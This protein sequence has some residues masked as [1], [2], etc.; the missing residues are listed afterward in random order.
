VLP[1]RTQATKA[2][3]PTSRPSQPAA[4][5]QALAKIPPLLWAYLGAVVLLLAI[6]L[7]LP[8]VK[9]GVSEAYTLF[10]NNDRRAIE[11]WVAGFGLWG[12]VLILVL[13]IGQTI[14]SAIP[15]VLVL[16]VA[17]VA[18]GPIWGGVLGWFGA[19]LAALVGYGL[20]RSFGDGLQA[21]FVSAHLREII[22]KN[23]ARYG[24]WAILAL[25]ISPLVPSDGV[26]FVAGL[27]KMGFW[28]FLAGTIGGVTPV[29][30]AVAYFGSDFG[31]LQL[32][33]VVVT[34]LSLGGLLAFVLWDKLL[35]PKAVA[36]AADG[37]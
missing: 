32:G 37:A 28:P 3:Q 4:V 12:P 34:A 11:A 33:L 22:A 16:I 10:V 14:V 27:V 35:R 17:V 29:V 18:Y 15:M 1:D 21:H 25:R 2:S 7:W 31:R 9:S 20:G 24:C 26:S 36:E 5:L 23:V 13:M 6:Y 30:V 8:G 19:I